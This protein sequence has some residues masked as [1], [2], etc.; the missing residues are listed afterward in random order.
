VAAKLQL[1]IWFLAIYLI[2]QAKTGLL[3]LA[4]K[5]QLDLSRPTAS[6][7]HHKMILCAM[8]RR[9]G[10]IQLDDANR[11]GVQRLIFL[12]SSCIYPHDFP[13]PSRNTTCLPVRWSPPTIRVTSPGLRNQAR[14]KL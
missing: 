11:S 2:S 12:G 4:L 3:A 13:K 7:L 6:P 5:R 9:D 10:Q 8:A 14:R 1:T